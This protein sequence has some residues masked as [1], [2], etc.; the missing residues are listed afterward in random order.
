MPRVT[1]NFGAVPKKKQPFVFVIAAG[2]SKRIKPLNIFLKSFV[3]EIKA[4]SI[5]SDICVCLGILRGEKDIATWITGKKLL[6]VDDC[7]YESL[8]ETEVCSLAVLL[9][10]LNSS[11]SR[12]R[13][14][15]DMSILPTIVFLVDETCVINEWENEMSLLLNNKWYKRATLATVGLTENIDKELLAKLTR[16]Y[17]YVVYIPDDEEL[18]TLIGR[19]MAK[20]LT[21]LIKSCSLDWALE[22]NG[23]FINAEGKFELKADYLCSD[24]DDDSWE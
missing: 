3:E 21:P 9:A 5:E 11:L 2:A 17:G 16:D 4:L 6:P 24:W 15:D 19:S 13:L 20:N 8:A 14:M 22:E 18:L 1:C 23:V 12:K 7:C 10:E